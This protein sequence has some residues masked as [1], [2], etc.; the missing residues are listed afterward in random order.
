M[1]S[2]ILGLSLALLGANALAEQ[3]TM[4]VYMNKGKLEYIDDGPANPS[5]GDMYVRQGAVTFESGG[6]AV[7]EYFTRATLVFLDPQQNKSVRSYFAEL[8]LPEGS[9]YKTDFL[10]LRDGKPI[11]KDHKHTGAIIGGTGKYA[12]IRGTYTLGVSPSGQDAK[13][14]LTYWLGQ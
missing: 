7:G 8:I 9:I 14:T 5:I 12:G 4:T 2:W 6:P 11:G 1:K 10:R 3:Q 13:T